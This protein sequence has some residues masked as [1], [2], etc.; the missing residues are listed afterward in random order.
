MALDDL[1]A[2]D[3]H[4]IAGVTKD[5]QDVFAT[6]D[7]L[8]ATAQTSPANR[9]KA[10]ALARRTAAELRGILMSEL[11]PHAAAARARLAEMES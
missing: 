8:L 11:E 9:Q 6:L 1:T 10:L 3:L 7:D 2:A 5:I 4:R